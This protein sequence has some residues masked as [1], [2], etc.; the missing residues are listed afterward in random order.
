MEAIT[1]DD[2]QVLT[3][4]LGRVPRGAVGIGARRADGTPQ[5]VVTEP[6]LPDGTPFPTT[7][8][9]SDPELVRGC[10]RLE[11]NHVMEQF[12]A[13]LA[14][15]PELASAYRRAHEDYLHRRSELGEVPEIT[16]ISAG[17]M[18][19]RVKCLHALVGHALVAGPGVNP[20]GDRALEMLQGHRV[21]AID[22]GTNS[23][24]LL[25]AETYPQLRDLVREMRIV[26][27]GQDV[28]R[29][30]QLQPEAIERTLAAVREYQ[31]LI[32]EYGV[33]DV[34]FVA[35]SAM[36]DARNGADFIAA[37]QDIMGVTPQVVPGTMEAALTFR[38]ATAF[39][40][41]E[42][43][44]LVVDIGGGSTEFVLDG[45]KS[46]SVDMGSVRVTEMFTSLDDARAWVDEQLAKVMSFQ[47][48]RSVVGVAGTVTTLA[49]GALGATEYSPELTHGKFLTW[50]QWQ[51]AIDFI[52]A[53]PLEVRA[54]LGYMP[55]GRADVI[56]AGAVIWERILLR[57]RE[58]SPELRGA[59]V[60]EHD[61]LD[62][63]AL[64]PIAQWQRQ[65]T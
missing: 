27:L 55:A 60:S 45:D 29:T 59:Y 61:I 21:A 13:E 58:S 51:D 46:I 17:G 25:I 3:D 26:R 32:E 4:Q 10:S 38:G 31:K 48:V 23:I 36:R 22:C 12:N 9:L 7:F 39:V 35:T 16:N 64:A 30:G 24:R 8:Y 57:L 41:E 11:A 53:A 52:V 14:E 47:S 18:P 2:L 5:V 62:G 56:P 54:A 49:A 37:V 1:A 42:P 34:R 33:E 40:E 28:N 63:I 20:I 65:S 44:T 6:R 15:D 43:P 50:Q 19:E